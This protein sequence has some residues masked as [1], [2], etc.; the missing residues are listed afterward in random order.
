MA[1]DAYEAFRPYLQPEMRLEMG[2]PLSGGG[3][4]RVPRGDRVERDRLVMLRVF[5]GREA[6]E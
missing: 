6:R 1:N 5:H 2:I 3:V 4:F